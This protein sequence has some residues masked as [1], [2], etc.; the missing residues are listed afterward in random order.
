MYLVFAK[1]DESRESSILKFVRKSNNSRE[2]CQFI[3]DALP[4]SIAGVM[5]PGE[6]ELIRQRI[7][8][9]PEPKPVK[10]DRI[11]DFKTAAG[12]F[13]IVLLSTFPVAIPFLFHSNLQIALRISNAIGILMMFF[14]GWGLGKYAGRNSLLTGITI[15]LFGIILVTIAIALG[16]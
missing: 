15:S 5:Q 13:L 3:T 10:G 12:I 14:C 8:L 4:S 7:A 2:A 6:I 1:T 9:S 11:K 16:G